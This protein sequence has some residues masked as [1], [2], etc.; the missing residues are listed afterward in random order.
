MLA[1]RC[2]TFTPISATCATIAV[3]SVTTGTTCA[4]TVA[5][6]VT[7]A[8]ICAPT[9]AGTNPGGYLLLTWGEQPLALNI[10]CLPQ[11]PRFISS[12]AVQPVGC[13]RR[14]QLGAP[15]PACTDN[16]F[17]PRPSVTLLAPRYQA[18]F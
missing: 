16:H 5:I 15:L 2:A 6:C 3:T 17:R 18:Y 9:V 10:F 14:V 1:S 12:A 13:R 8:V 11:H 7:T 4:T